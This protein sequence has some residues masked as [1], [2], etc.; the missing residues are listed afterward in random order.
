MKHLI[1]MVLLGIGVFLNTLAQKGTNSPLI[2]EYDFFND[3]ISTSPIYTVNQNTS[4]EL[5][6]KNVN[7]LRYK[8]NFTEYRKNFTNSTTTNGANSEINVLSFQFNPSQYKIE[9]PADLYITR[10]QQTRDYFTEKSKLQES[11]LKLE[12]I[13]EIKKRYDELNSIKSD[14]KEEQDKIEESKILLKSNLNSFGFTE[15]NFQ[16]KFIELQSQ[17]NSLKNNLEAYYITATNSSIVDIEFTDQIKL[18]QKSI[19]SLEQIGV[20]YHSL[21][22]IAESNQPAED[23]INDKNDLILNFFGKDL[24]NFEIIKALNEKLENERQNFLILSEKY[25]KTQSQN[26]DSGYSNAAK[27]VFNNIKNQR[28]QINKNDFDKLFNEIIRV[29]DFLV[30]ENFSI[31]YKTL[32]LPGNMD[33]IQYNFKAEPKSNLQNSIGIKPV[34]LNY[35]VKIRGGTRIDISTGVF[36]NFLTF[37]STY[38]YFK[39]PIDENKTKINAE[40][41]NSFIPDFGVLFHLYRRSISDLKLGGSFGISTDTQRIA[42]YLG[43]SVLIGR[44]ERINFNFGLSGRQVNRM[45]FHPEGMTLNQAIESLPSPIVP[46]LD[47]APFRIGAFVG[48]S[49]NLLNNRENEYLEKLNSNR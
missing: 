21:L 29:L 12:Q 40:N 38:T 17:I 19:D 15:E 4:V 22:V 36:W 32:S 18:H 35:K 39:D 14:I 30:K 9:I 13:M 48:L 45:A 49:F 41:S 3:A 6:I 16:S 25:S 46:L 26:I 37:D 5:R 23:I 10:T 7:P 28:S 8:L 11:Q 2:I 42:Y 34:D 1:L 44:S 27:E 24:R 31:T 20:F 43:A 47:P 33:F